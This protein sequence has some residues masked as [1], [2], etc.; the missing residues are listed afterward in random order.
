MPHI[1][2]STLLI[3]IALMIAMVAAACDTAAE[4]PTAE[5]PTAVPTVVSESASTSEGEPAG[6]IREPGDRDTT[7]AASLADPEV[8]E[9][10]AGELG[11]DLS[12]GEFDLT[13]LRQL[14]PADTAAAF[15]ACGAEFGR[16]GGGGGI[17]GGGGFVGGGFADPEIRECL[18]GILG[19]DALDNLGQGSGLGL[20]PES[21]AAFEECG[22][23]FGDTGGGFQFGGGEGAFGGD[24]GIFG[25]G[26]R[27]GRGG[28]GGDGSFQEC[29]I[30]ELGEDALASLRNPTGAPPA[31][32]QAAL[33]KCGG[34]IAIPVEPDGGIG[35]GAGPIPIETITE[36]TATSIPVSELTIEQLTCLSSE[37][38]PADLAAAVVATSAGDLS[39]V[40]DELLAALQTC[41]VGS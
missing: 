33:E 28:F 25:G 22:I 26:L 6:R 10:L 31:D 23:N 3:S 27:G 32:F 9:C 15:T 14:D 21:L 39:E 11:M 37:L 29:L 35:N 8:Q 1:S 40:S 24:S 4:K 16:S 36:P 7:G 30:G 38:D 19:D 34:G 12:T 13:S 20:E 18:T 17:L 2:R 41:G 5:P